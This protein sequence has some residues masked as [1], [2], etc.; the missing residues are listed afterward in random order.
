MENEIKLNTKT[1]LWTTVDKNT[2]RLFNSARVKEGIPTY[3][4]FLRLIVERYLNNPPDTNRLVSRDRISKNYEELMSRYEKQSKEIKLLLALLLICQTYISK[5]AGTNLSDIELSEALYKSA[6]FID[7][8]EEIGPAALERLMNDIADISNFNSASKEYNDDLKKTNIEEQSENKTEKNQIKSYDPEELTVTNFN[9]KLF[10]KEETINWW[11]HIYDQG[12]DENT[13]KNEI[14][15]EVVFFE[16]SDKYPEIQNI[17]NEGYQAG[18]VGIEYANGYEAIRNDL[19]EKT[20]GIKP[21][22]YGEPINITDFLNRWSDREGRA[23]I[24]NS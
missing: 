10:K 12:R 13:L 2:L 17:I 6:A 19:I 24:P 14:K 11:K 15:R 4:E 5:T 22:A 3:S 1:R 18:N 8:N 9:H 23:S 20:T 16:T 7:N 21:I